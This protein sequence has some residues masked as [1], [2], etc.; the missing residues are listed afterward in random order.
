MYSDPRSPEGL[1]RAL[2]AFSVSPQRR[3]GQ[4]FLTDRA[5]FDVIADEVAAGTEGDVLEIG[6]GPGGLTLSL[7]ERGMRV[8]AIEI[9]AVMGRLLAELQ[10]Q[11]PGRL[12][13]VEGDAVALSWGRVAD[14]AKM[15]EPVVVTGNLPYYVTA[16]LLAK[17][18][19]D[20]LNWDKAV[21]MVQREVAERLAALPGTRETTALSVM[22]RYVADVRRICDVSAAVF[23]P[24]PEVESSVIELKRVESPRVALPRFRWAVRAGFGHRR[25]M[26]RQALSR[27]ARSPYDAAGWSERLARVGID[28]TRRAETLTFEEWIRLAEIVPDHVILRK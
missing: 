22:V 19:E 4:H 27:E 7:L 1:R 3:L 13:V 10:P 12:D 18:W 6:P 8:T 23:L 15:A 14:S 17:L 16:P 26:L 21:V 20:T 11:F 28:P 5:V 24:V 9:D 25:K 2:A